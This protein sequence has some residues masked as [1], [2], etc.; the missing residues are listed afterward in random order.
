MIVKTLVENTSLSQN[1]GHEHGLS[2][3]LE[4]KDHSIL[5]DV[6]A[7]DLFLENAKKL[8]VT[9]A[10][11]DFLV[12]SHG[13][14][15]HG[16]GL[17]AFLRENSKAEVFIHEQAFGKHYKVGQDGELNFIGL[18]NELQQYK[19]ITF[20]S[21]R[22]LITK[23]TQLFSNVVPPKLCSSSN[24]ALVMKN[25]QITPDTFG[26]EQHLAI[27]EDGKL[28]LF[29]G[30]AHNGIRNII[31]HFYAFEGRMP[32]HVVGGF[33]LYDRVGGPED[34]ALD[35]LGK[36]LF[37]TGAKYYTGHC[38]GIE[39]YGR[40]EKVMGE[41]IGYLATGSEMKL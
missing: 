21:D 38:T 35:E 39:P 28:F 29:T 25:G 26:H 33:H 14:Y 27:E 30:C 13:H 6:G 41:R 12:I 23:Q 24:S 18:D 8:G 31:Q 22:L 37:A 3:Y 32:D 17:E 34:L 7:S 5:F 15:D 11:I 40:L 36:Y 2:L 20:T 9:I 10:D 16:G 19:Q 1:Y 4:T